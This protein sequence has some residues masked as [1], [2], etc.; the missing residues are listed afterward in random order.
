MHF[1]RATYRVQLHKD[2]K[3]KD[4]QR[5]IPYLNK[6]GI[7]TIYA[8]PFFEAT[9]GSM[10]GYDVLNPHRI[11]P[12]IGTLDEFRKIAN[13]L[14]ALNMQWLQDIVPNHMAFSAENPWLYDIMEKGQ[15]SPYYRF[16]D[17]DWLYPEKEFYGRLMIPTL[18]D[19]LQEVLAKGELK[20]RLGEKGFDFTYYDN[21]FPLNI[22]SYP[23]LLNTHSDSLPQKTDDQNLITDYL[24]L[25]AEVEKF[26]SELPEAEKATKDWKPLK[27]RLMKMVEQH[28]VIRELLEEAAES[29]NQKP[30]RV[31]R[32]LDQQSYRPVHWKRTETQINY[33]R[34][35]TVNDLICLNMQEQPVFDEYHRFIKELLDEGLI[36]GLR[37]DHID[38]LLDPT[39]YTE[40]LRK[41]AGD[42]VYIVVEKILEAEEEMPNFWPIEGSSGYD[43][44]ARVNQ[45][46]TDRKGEEALL[47][48]YQKIAPQY[49]DY[50][51]LVYRNK[52]FILE[53]R[54]AGELDNLIRLME[55]LSL[56]PY[57]NVKPDKKKLRAALGHFLIAFPLYRIYANKLPYP[58]EDMQV[59]KDTFERIEQ[60]FPEL[61]IYFQNLHLV[62]NGV[63]DG[64]EEENQNKLYFN[65][66]AMQFTGPLAAKGVEDTTFYQYSPLISHNEVGDSPDKLGMRPARFHEQMQIRPMY[67]MN[68]TGTHDT[69]RGEDARMRLNLLSEMP[70]K[71]AETFKKWQYHNE[72]HFHKSAEVRMPDENDEYFLY[73]TLIATYPF[74]R[75]PQDADYQPRLKDYI[76]K[77]VKEAKLHTSWA[78]PNEEYEEATMNFIDHILADEAFMDHFTSFAHDLACK[79]VVYSL[80]Q[81]LLKLTVPGLPD[82]YQGSEFWDLSMVDPDNRRPVNYEKRQ[83]MLAHLE[84][85]WQEDPLEII[86]QLKADL[87]KPD[88]KMFTLYQGL[89]LRQQFLPIFARGEYQPLKTGGKA[90]D[91][92]FAFLRKSGQAAALVLVPLHVQ[93]LLKDEYLPLGENCWGDTYLE[94]PGLSGEWQCIFTRKEYQLADQISVAELLSD[95]PLCLLTKN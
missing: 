81:T 86:A 14:K 5:I 76:L 17:I 94:L 78:E 64:S 54:M 18:G 22:C 65:M 66:R 84:K 6:L 49:P 80:S 33:R 12:E 10:H 79:A 55:D 45:L 70:G 56:I 73:Q 24:S 52:K 35:F 41:L 9:P 34:F 32:I 2:F 85:N 31:L 13:D 61:D 74:H 39:T 83:E 19:P 7:S 50:H 37:V 57:E 95:F 44:L 75:T 63:D 46:L 23:F 88:I 53:E 71:W 30:E 38:G 36:Q 3:F 62:F 40:R 69:K 27:A 59:I 47:A 25:A 43:F 26:V 51:E 42:D 87:I 48:L 90:G 8:A 67:N 11:N 4:L 60:Q 29:Q 92:V 77:A 1:P 68:A 72:R 93:S 91:K 15:H 28:T 20:L 58:D 21:F 82:V 89:K 16:F